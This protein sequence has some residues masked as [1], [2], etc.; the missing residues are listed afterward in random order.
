MVISLVGGVTQMA[1]VSEMFFNLGKPGNQVSAPKKSQKH[2]Y[3]IRNFHDFLYII[4]QQLPKKS[5]V[6]HISLPPHLPHPSNCLPHEV[7]RS[8]ARRAHDVEEGDTKGV[9][10]NRH[11]GDELVKPQ[12]KKAIE[13][14]ATKV[15]VDLV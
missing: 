14:K 9:T 5:Q 4:F 2:L 12:K 7:H 3:K 15:C 6:F 13:T 10:F 1:T 11:R 8:V